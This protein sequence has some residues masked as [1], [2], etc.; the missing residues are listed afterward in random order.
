MRTALGASRARLVRQVVVE[1]A[2]LALARQP[3]RNRHRLAHAAGAGLAIPSDVPRVGEIT[4]DWTVLTTV[5][6]ASIAVAV[7]GRGHPGGLV[8]APEPAA[9]APPVAR[10]RHAEA[11]GATLG[12]LVSVQIALAVV[13]GIGA[14]LMLRYVLE[15]AAR[16]SRVPPG[17]RPDIPPADDVEV[18]AL[19][20]TGCRTCSATSIAFSALPA[21]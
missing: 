7:S 18:Q 10:H 12:A 17:E 19:A 2:V 9:A 21:S 5:L 13:L 14:A 20:Q 8:G 11:A 15:S 1:Q 16:R 4:L 3:R 6:A